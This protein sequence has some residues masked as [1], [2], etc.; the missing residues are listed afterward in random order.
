MQKILMSKGLR[1]GENFTDEGMYLEFDFCLIACDEIEER[2]TDF[3]RRIKLDRNTSDDDISKCLHEMIDTIKKEA[4]SE[5][6]F[7]KGE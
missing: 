2:R 1:K 7:I 3:V 5:L 6:K 4:S